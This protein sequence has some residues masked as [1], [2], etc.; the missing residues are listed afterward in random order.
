MLTII[1]SIQ[2]FVDTALICLIME[3]HHGLSCTLPSCDKLKQL[4]VL[5]FSSHLRTFRCHNVPLT[6]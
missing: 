5:T 2:D 6:P 4:L 3:N 1:L